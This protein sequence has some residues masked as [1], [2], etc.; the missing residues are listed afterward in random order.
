MSKI[1]QMPITI[2]EKVEVKLNKKELVV[3]GP[4]GELTQEISPFLEIEIKDNQIKITRK[5]EKKLAKSMHGL[6]RTLINNMILGVTQGFE[7]TLEVHGTGYRVTAKGKGLSVTLGFSHP[8]EIEPIEGISLKAPDNKTIV[9]SGI[10]KQRVGQ[11]AAQIRELK[12]PDPYKAKGIR[13]QGEQIKRKPGKLG[14]AAEGA[15][16]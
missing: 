10:N 8:V 9:V 15:A 6:T 5:S 12:K 11:M 13:Y 7:K 3:K 4:K 2:P 1:G 16:T 14:K